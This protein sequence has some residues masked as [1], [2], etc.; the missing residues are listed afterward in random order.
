MTIE[1]GLYPQREN[2]L[3][4]RESPN[5]KEVQLLAKATACVVVFM[6]VQPY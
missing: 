2:A 1:V 3:I 4:H 5:G 6:H